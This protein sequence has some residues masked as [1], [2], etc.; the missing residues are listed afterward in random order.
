MLLEHNIA[1]NESLKENASFKVMYEV[2]FLLKTRK[3]IFMYA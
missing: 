1:H 3:Q 2:Y